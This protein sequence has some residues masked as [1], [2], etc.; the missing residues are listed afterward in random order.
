M[1]FFCTFYFRFLCESGTLQC[2]NF[3]ANTEMKNANKKKNKYKQLENDNIEGSDG[4]IIKWKE[5]RK[6]DGKE[7]IMMLT[8]KMTI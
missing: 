6:S 2:R 3:M 7:A 5:I 4:Q 8:L 1:P